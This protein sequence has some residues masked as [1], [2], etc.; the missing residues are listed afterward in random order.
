MDEKNKT[1]EKRDKRRYEEVAKQTAAAI[2]AEGPP[3]VVNKS[4]NIKENPPELPRHRPPR[5]DGRYMICR[6]FFPSSG[7]M[8]FETVQY[9][10][11]LPP[12][13]T[14]REMIIY[15]TRLRLSNS[16]QEL[17]DLYHEDE[18]AVSFDHD[19]IQQHVVEHFGY[20]HVN[21][22]RTALHRFPDDPVVQSA[23]YGNVSIEIA[24]FP[25]Y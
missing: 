11:E 20:R 9:S 6:M 8:G 2:E 14:L 18:G 13:E 22:L 4:T 17:M 15:E 21:A 23:F 3:P 1:S 7:H 24:P 25:L 16:I 10:D 12:I 5:P 19:L